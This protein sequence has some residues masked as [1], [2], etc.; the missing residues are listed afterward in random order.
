MNDNRT[1]S[2][3]D[4]IVFFR[5]PMKAMSNADRNHIDGI[6][7]EYPDISVRE[8]IDFWIEGVYRNS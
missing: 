5:S 8:L 3:M 4:I 2:M 7:E 1:K 6:L